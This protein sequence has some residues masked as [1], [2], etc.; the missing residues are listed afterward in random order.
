M[1]ISISL[2]PDTAKCEEVNLE[3]DQ[4]MSVKDLKDVVS[5][6]GLH[7]LINESNKKQ[8][9]AYHKER[10]LINRDRVANFPVIRLELPSVENSVKFIDPN[11]N[12][13]LNVRMGKD[14]PIS[15]A[16]HKWYHTF[17]EPVQYIAKGA[18]V[19]SSATPSQ[20]G[21][22]KFEERVVVINSGRGILI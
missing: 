21:W 15:A 14:C 1:E 5:A 18:V 19:S 3:A 12:L 10:V 16:I 2:P 17:D 22:T 13:I 4:E 20:I 9:R 7:P 8:L 11:T 6:R